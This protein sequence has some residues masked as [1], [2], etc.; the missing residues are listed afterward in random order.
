[1]AIERGGE[2]VWRFLIRIVLVLFIALF[3]TALWVGTSFETPRIPLNHRRAVASIRSV[4]LAQQHHAGQHPAAGFA[5]NLSE[6]SD[7]ESVAPGA[8]FIDRV[9]ASGTK[10]AYHFE[11]RCVRSGNEKTMTYTITAVPTIPGNTGVYALC[12]DQ[13]GGIW[14][15]KDGST[16][17]CLAQHKPIEQKYR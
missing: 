14:Y 7:R 4:N 11:I 15:S 10:A 6:L 17:D 12:S 9:L 2:T 8:G 16:S 3:I 13:S 1:M 5:C